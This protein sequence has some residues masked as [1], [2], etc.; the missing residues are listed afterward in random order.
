MHYLEI[1][2]YSGIFAFGGETERFREC[3]IRSTL[4]FFFNKVARSLQEV[5]SSI[6]R[7]FMS[8]MNIDT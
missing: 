1:V 7:T 8:E 5:K 2:E 6:L 4:S 3:G